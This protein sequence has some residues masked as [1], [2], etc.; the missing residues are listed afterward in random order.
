MKG[1]DGNSIVLREK[2]ILGGNVGVILLITLIGN[3]ES[4]I[5]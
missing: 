3:G 5:P 4:D 1:A 2:H